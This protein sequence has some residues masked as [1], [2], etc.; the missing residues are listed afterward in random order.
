V[1]THA[2]A[3][4][5]KNAARQ[6]QPIVFVDESGLSER[7]H[8]VRTWAPR[9]Q[10]PVLQYHFNWHTLSAIAGIT[11]WTFYFRLFPGAIKSPQVVLFLQHLLRHL[12]GPVLVIWDGLRQHRSALVRDFVAAQGGRLALEFL[13]G[14]ASELN[15]VAYLWGHWKHP[16]RP[17]FCPR[18][19]WTLS[20]EA[21]RALRRMR[22][23][24][25]LV[26]ACWQ[27]AELFG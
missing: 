16:E 4:G 6:G 5:K 17:N 13:P 18:D 12:R 9:G 3:G 8:R 27:Q 23:R 7:P 14:D 21:R 25:T 22:R 15:P 10:T 19:G 20:T 26:T 11:W 24:P 1:E 2:L